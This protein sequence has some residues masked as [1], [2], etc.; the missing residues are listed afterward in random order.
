MHTARAS[1]AEA[2]NYGSEMFSSREGNRVTSSIPSELHLVLPCRLGQY[3][4][5]EH[6]LLQHIT[7]PALG[8]SSKAYT[9]IFILS[10]IKSCLSSIH[11]WSPITATMQK[12][13]SLTLLLFLCLYFEIWQCNQANLFSIYKSAPFVIILP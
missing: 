7:F 11:F 1:Q 6:A 12:Y 4:A 13:F 9:F 3:S 10:L 8:C 5:T 2:V